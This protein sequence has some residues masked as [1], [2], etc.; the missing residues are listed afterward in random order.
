MIKETDPPIMDQ[1][2][3]GTWLYYKPIPFLEDDNIT[4]DLQKV[5]DDLGGSPMKIKLHK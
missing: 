4:A 3:N 2:D 1:L 5:K